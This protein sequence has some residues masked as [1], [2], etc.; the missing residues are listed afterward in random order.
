MPRAQVNIGL[1]GTSWWADSMYLPALA[2]HARA[3]VA[4]LCGRDR[5]RAEALADSWNVPRVYTDY[6]AM[7]RAENLDA[8]VIAGANDT[9]HPATMAAL[10]HNLHVLCEKPLALSV[11]EAAE[12][13]QAAARAGAVT[14]VPFTYRFMPSNQFIKALLDDGYIGRPYHLAM[15]YYTGFGRAPDYHWR[16]DKA[17][18][19]SGVIGDLG[20]HFLH[21]AEWF[22]GDITAVTCHASALV[23][24]APAPDRAP[25]EQTEDN[26]AFLLEFAGGAN[27]VVTVSSLAHE[28]TPFGQRHQFEFHGDAGTLYAENDWDKTEVVRGARAGSD[29]GLAPMEI[30]A[31][32][33]GAARRDSVHN[34]YRD[35]FRV[36]QRMTGEWVDAIL[37][38]CAVQPDFAAGLRVQRVMDAALRSA[39]EGRRVTVDC[40][41]A[42]GRG[43]DGDAG[44]GDASGDRGDGDG[45]D[46]RDRDTG[47]RGES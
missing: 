32:H 2:A 11:A 15:R 9:H 35:I 27:G 8:V 28:P 10:Q 37:A 34:T 21:L 25:Y 30:P 19:G 26:A 40:G 31:G 29:A 20:S 46:S 39:A 16:F 45:V 47:D 12:M 24:R 41:D 43:C 13:T 22:Y 42:G 14:M 36:E 23:K 33:Y 6:R 18:A 5:G 44:D 38:G 7:F 17:K 3:V 4:A 1:I